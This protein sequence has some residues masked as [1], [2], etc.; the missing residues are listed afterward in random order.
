MLDEISQHI[1]LKFATFLAMKIAWNEETVNTHPSWQ[2]KQLFSV[3]STFFRT[4]SLREGAVSAEEPHARKENVQK[5][6]LQGSIDWTTRMD[7]VY[8]SRYVVEVRAMTTFLLFWRLLISNV[9]YTLLP[10]YVLKGYYSDVLRGWVGHQRMLNLS[11]VLAFSV[12]FYRYLFRIY[13]CK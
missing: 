11:L 3:K 5:A 2:K 8:S 4:D 1:D 12:K 6:S 7:S 10:N 13:V 9:V